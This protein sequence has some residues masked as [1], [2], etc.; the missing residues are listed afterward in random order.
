MLT[1]RTKN[2]KNQRR[3]NILDNLLPS[4][5]IDMVSVFGFLLSIYALYEISQV[6]KSFTTKG[7]IPDIANDLEKISKS[8]LKN[9]GNFDGKNKILYAEI[10]QFVALLEANLSHIS[11]EDKSKIEEFIKKQKNIEPPIQVDLA[12]EIYGELSSIVTY[13]QEIDKNSRWE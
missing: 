8:F 1:L 9:I 13:T 7:R 4:W 6:K 5:M 10:Q 11:K 2:W 3:Y 12:W